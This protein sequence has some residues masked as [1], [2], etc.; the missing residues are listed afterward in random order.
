M[1]CKEQQAER[2]ENIK[3]PSAGGTGPTYLA[4]RKD[5]EGKKKGGSQQ[6]R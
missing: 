1:A 6:N 5:P 4:P 2:E 3:G